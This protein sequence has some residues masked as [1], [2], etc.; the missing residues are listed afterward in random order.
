MQRKMHINVTEML[1]IRAP[2]KAGIWT[3][4]TKAHALPAG[5]IE[6]AVKI[7]YFFNHINLLGANIKMFEINIKML[8]LDI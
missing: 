6:T 2:L 3:Q 4:I 1:H 7:D 8:I 5:P